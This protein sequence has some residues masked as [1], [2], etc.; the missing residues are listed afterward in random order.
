MS[1]RQ[2]KSHAGSG[3]AANTA[4]G[5]LSGAG[6]GS[7]PSSQLSYIQ[8]PPDYSAISDP[9]VVVAFKNL[10]KKDATTK[11]KALEDMHTYVTSPSHEVEDAVLESWVRC[12]P[13]V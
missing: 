6:F 12:L 9:H 8:E 5:T 11:T 7:T 10:S 2:F 3:R 4:F 13:C 1:K